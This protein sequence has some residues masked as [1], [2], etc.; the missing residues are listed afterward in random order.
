[1]ARTGIA[2][3]V[4]AFGDD[5]DGNAARVSAHQGA[6][7]RLEILDAARE[8]IYARGYASAS[9]RDIAAAV[10]VTQA[11]L[12]YHFRNK[13]EILFALIESFTDMLSTQLRAALDTDE[14]PVAGL[15][16]A[17]R[18]HILL[19]PSHYREFKLVS[20]DK[21]LLG[22]R[23]RDMVRKREREIYGLYK[24][25]IE[26]LRE[27][28]LLAGIEVSVCTFNILAMINFVAQWYQ[29]D[30]PLTLEDVADQTVALALN[31]LL[32][33]PPA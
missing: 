6:A 20:E 2:Q 3:S 25:R 14:E 28:G 33:R 29:P 9:M 23:F 7:R 12:Y 10:G 15:R 22:G 18:T 21:K 1:M 19:V 24:G 27:A 30:G 32:A 26:E 5:R 11:A 16:N 31:G 17:I 13:E 8:L 4:D